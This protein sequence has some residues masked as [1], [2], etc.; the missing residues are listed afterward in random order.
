MKRLLVSLAVVLV[1]VVIPVVVYALRSD[2]KGTSL[3]AT[4]GR[5]SLA[6]RQQHRAACS[7]IDEH[8]TI[9]LNGPI[10]ETGTPFANAL[11]R[12]DAARGIDAKVDSGRYAIFL[13]ID[14]RGTIRTNV[15][16]LVDMSTG[17]RDLGT[18]TPAEPWEPTGVP[19][20]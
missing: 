4:V 2:A 17:S 3:R 16:G 14:H 5:C 11:E 6:Q 7:Y 15:R 20:A 10:D 1:I 9:D 13:E 12:A 18:I 19:G 8:P